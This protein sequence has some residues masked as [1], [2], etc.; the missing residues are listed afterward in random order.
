V[1]KYNEFLSQIKK[2]E[3]SAI[4]FSLPTNFFGIQPTVKA[5]AHNGSNLPV[6]SLRWKAQLYI[7]EG[8]EPVA[9]AEPID[10][11]KQGLKPGDTVRRTYVIGFVTGDQSWSTLE[12]QNASSRRVVL[13]AEPDTFKDYGNRYYMGEAPPYNELDRRRAAVATAKQLASY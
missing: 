10:I 7:N 13:T 9:V 4:S 12:I 3:A 11:F 1:S 5:T 6:S 2:I 8:K